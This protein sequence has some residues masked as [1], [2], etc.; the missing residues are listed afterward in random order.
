MGFHDILYER[1]KSHAV[2]WA[3]SPASFVIVG[4]LEADGFSAKEE[5]LNVLKSHREELER[6]AKGTAKHQQ[7]Q[8]DQVQNGDTGKQA[9]KKQEVKAVEPAVKTGTK[10]LLEKLV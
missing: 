4:L 1:I 6:S 10:L 7:K 9:G 2:K 3:T 8:R 5:L